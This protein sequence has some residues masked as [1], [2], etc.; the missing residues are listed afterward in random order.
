MGGWN[1]CEQQAGNAGAFR[2]NG[3][4]CSCTGNTI[5]NLDVCDTFANLDHRPCTAVS[6]RDRLI[7]T[8]ANRRE[9]GSEPVPANFADHITHYVR[10]CVRLLQE[11]FAGEF[12]RS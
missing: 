2:V 8:A 12:R 1:F 9:G 5:A 6:E 4:S 7:E 11:I 3:V 10:A